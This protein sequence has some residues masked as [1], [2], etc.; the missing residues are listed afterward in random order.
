LH[1]SAAAL[2]LPPADLLQPLLEALQLGYP[3]G[4]KAALHTLAGQ[5]TQYAEFLR[6]AEALAANFQLDALRSLAQPDKDQT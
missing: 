4:V 3:K 2:S 6:R 1:A 5:T